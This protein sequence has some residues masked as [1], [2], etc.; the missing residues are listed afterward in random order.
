MRTIRLIHKWTGLLIGLF[1]LFSCLSGLMIVIGKIIGSYAPFFKWTKEFHTTLF[2][3]D[4][5]EK[6]IAIATLLALMEIVT[7]Y[8]LWIRRTVALAHSSKNHWRAIKRNIGF[9]FP[10]LLS[11]T[12]NAGGFWCG[13]PVLLMILTSLT[14][15]FGWYS[16]II[17]ALFD[18]PS[19]FHTLHALHTGS[20]E[21]NF[22]RVLWLAATALAATL[23]ITG[24]LL[25]LRHRKRKR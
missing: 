11:G 6:I 22:S 1:F 14:W 12:H 13:I 5:G 7:G 21:G 8:L 20:W 23:P 24:L 15:C 25:T 10:N 17:Y 19:L 4:T 16:D 2:L 18:A 9:T 3:G